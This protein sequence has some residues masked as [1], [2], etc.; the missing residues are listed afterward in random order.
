MIRKEIVNQL[1]KCP[2]SLIILNDLQ[3]MDMSIFENLEDFFEGTAYTES[4]YKR[5]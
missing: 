1:R 5:F 2:K 3:K 4:F